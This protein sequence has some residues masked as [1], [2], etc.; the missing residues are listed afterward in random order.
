M[1]G[2]DAEFSLDDA[3]LTRRGSRSGERRW[4]LAGLRRAEIGVIARPPGPPLRSLVLVFERGR[5]VISSQGYA[6]LGPPRDLTPAFT[7]FARALLAAAAEAAPDAGF[8]RA[9]S[10]AAGALVWAMLLIG[11]GALATLAAALFGGAF[12]LGLDLGARL[13][14]I[15]LVV[16]SA[17][18]WVAESSRRRFD[19]RHVPAELLPAP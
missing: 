12:A 6:G 4:P 19:P 16:A 11:F 7:P 17:W 10:Q 8:R 18:P 13:V 14:F 9:R 15:L 1:L 2:E 5:V 3:V